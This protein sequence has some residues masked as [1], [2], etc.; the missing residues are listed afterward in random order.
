MPAWRR[1]RRA[2]GG[3]A[4]S[5][6]LE[7]LDPVGEGADPAAQAL[8]VAGAGD[9]ERAERRLLCLRGPLAGAEGLA[10]RLAEQRVLEQ[11]LG[12]VADRLLAARAEAAVRPRSSPFLRSP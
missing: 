1:L 4:S 2:P 7:G 5:V 12:E 11:R 6:V 9:V 3:V 8:E 10:E